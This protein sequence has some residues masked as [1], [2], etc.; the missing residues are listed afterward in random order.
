MGNDTNL[1]RLAVQPAIRFK[2]FLLLLAA[3]LA[4][5]P[6]YPPNSHLMLRFAPN[7]S[8]AGEFLL[9][10]LLSCLATAL[11]ILLHSAQHPRWTG[12]ET[13]KERACA[14]ACAALYAA[15][16]T[17]VWTLLYLGYG[18]TLLFATLGVVSGACIAPVIMRW[19]RLFLMDFRS[20][21]LYGAIACA[22]A[23]A[24]AWFVS[25]LPDPIVVISE[26]VLVIAG[27][28]VP[29]LAG[30]REGSFDDARK[31]PRLQAEDA[32][33]HPSDEPDSGNPAGLASSLRAFLSIVWVP[34]LGFLVCS[35]MMA[36]YSF[37]ISSGA[38]RSEYTGGIVAS[39]I[40]VALCTIRM[41]SPLIMLVDRLAIPICI[42]AS[43]VLGGF[44][45]GTPL[46]I[47]GAMLV[48]VPLTLLSLFALSSLVAM[49]AAEELPLPFVFSAAF[50]LSCTV[51]LLGMTVQVNV[52]PDV[53][54]GPF[55]WIMLSAYFGIVVVH[56]GYVSWKQ[57]CSLEDPG[58]PDDAEAR[59][60]NDADKLHAMQD[61]RILA[62]ADEHS[63]TKRE[64][65]ILRYLSLGYG[66]V[67]I[68]KTLFISDNTARTHIK[69]IYRKLNVGSREELL[70]L[71]N[72]M[73]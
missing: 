19:T 27:S 24:A 69:N 71:V 66:S 15:A 4:S 21:M 60:E 45:A 72:S 50:L 31:S 61:E 73:R 48:Y 58:A 70:S 39:A 40:V 8:P 22:S 68:S 56:L 67:Y 46:F 2:P 51:S 43:L 23:S 53:D 28:M 29:V 41:K 12:F 9:A 26:S 49:A 3:F 1:G 63:L 32:C 59:I 35:F 62:L 34:L 65:E 47:A 64:H 42:A 54:L 18:N 14:T 44:P 52:S 7:V 6:L 37:D 13:R 17:A 10:M 30:S 20:V 25:L 57:A 16:L 55:L 5:A 11:V 38:V 33:T 36:T